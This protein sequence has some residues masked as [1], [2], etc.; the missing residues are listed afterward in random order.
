M[1]RNLKFELRHMHTLHEARQQY[2][3][4]SNF[5]KMEYVHDIFFKLERDWQLTPALVLKKQFVTFV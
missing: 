2:E 3:I 1:N 5:H 4:L